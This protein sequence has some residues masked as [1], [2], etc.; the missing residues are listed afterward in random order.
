[1]CSFALEHLQR[2]VK[3]QVHILMSEF[4]QNPSFELILVTLGLTVL[5]VYRIPLLGSCVSIILFIRCISC[6]GWIVRYEL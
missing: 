2:S 3:I 6:N 4:Y 1:M 5:G